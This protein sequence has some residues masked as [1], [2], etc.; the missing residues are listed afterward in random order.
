[1]RQAVSRNDRDL[2][3]AGSDAERAPATP[4][5]EPVRRAI[6]VPGLALGEPSA[7][8][9]PEPGGV[10]ALRRQADRLQTIRRMRVRGTVTP[11]VVSPATHDKHV[12]AAADQEKV[13]EGNYTSTTFVTN[14]ADLTGVV[15]ADN[16]NFTEPHGTRSAQMAVYANLTISQYDKATSKASGGWGAGKPVVKKIDAVS[17]P[18]EIG[19]AK[20]GVDEIQVTH[21]Q[22]V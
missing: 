15:D 19:V 20:N 22:A 4:D 7:R 3:R 16:H 8:A 5:A 9:L 21:F 13:A 6:A 18:C 11:S 2:A 17:T 14:D 1:M 10:P 12:A